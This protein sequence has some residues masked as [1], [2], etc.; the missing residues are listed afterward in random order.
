MH[1]P[2]RPALDFHLCRIYVPDR[3]DRRTSRQGPA[4]RIGLS[5]KPRLLRNRAAGQI[6]ELAPARPVPGVQGGGDRGVIVGDCP[7]TT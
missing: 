1:V 2:V 7:L 3:L 6:I 4:F 5:G